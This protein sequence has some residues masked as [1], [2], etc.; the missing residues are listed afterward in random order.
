M[1]ENKATFPNYMQEGGTQVR[2]SCFHEQ[3]WIRRR[4]GHYVSGRK[5]G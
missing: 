3:L 2:S 5:D 1:Q 4:M